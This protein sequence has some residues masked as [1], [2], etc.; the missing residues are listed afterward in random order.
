MILNIENIKA[1]YI[2]LEEHTEKNNKMIK[3]LNNFCNVERQPGVGLNEE[4]YSW[5]GRVSMAHKKAILNNY[6][7]NPVIIFEDDCV[8]FNYKKMIYIPDNA[9]IVFLGSWINSH[10][11]NVNNDISR[12]FGTRGAHAIL[13]MNE[14]GKAFM[15]ESIEEAIKKDL[16]HDYVFGENLEKI[17]AYMFNFPLFYQ[18]SEE[19]NTKIYNC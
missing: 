19:E 9:D 1:V 13:Y 12:V 7:E 8:K 16:W 5:Y 2:N 15:L 6:E 3:M 14:K 10:L 17:N 11:E 4:K 18:T